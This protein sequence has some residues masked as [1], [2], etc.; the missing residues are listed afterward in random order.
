MY[1]CTCLAQTHAVRGDR[2]RKVFGW[3]PKGPFLWEVLEE[4]LVKYKG[5]DPLR[6]LYPMHMEQDV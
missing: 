1:V 3:E 4:G 2:A 6:D 5:N